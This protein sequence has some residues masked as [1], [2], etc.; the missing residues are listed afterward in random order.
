MHGIVNKTH[1]DVLHGRFN[2]L[3]LVANRLLNVD[4]FDTPAIVRQ[5]VE[6]DDDVFIDLEGVGM[7]GNRRCPCA[8]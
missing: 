1:F 6:R 4:A 7:C 3:Q 8:V 5:P 2:D